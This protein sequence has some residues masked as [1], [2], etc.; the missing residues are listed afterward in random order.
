VKNR[1]GVQGTYRG[2]THCLIQVLTYSQNSNKIEMKFCKKNWVC[3]RIRNHKNENEKEKKVRK[4]TFGVKNK[5][6]L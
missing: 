2:I 6:G 5:G 3:G 4:K 1:R